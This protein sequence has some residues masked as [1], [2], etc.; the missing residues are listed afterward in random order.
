M[1]TKSNANQQ[2]QQNNNESGWR[3]DNEEHFK[4]LKQI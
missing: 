4:Y 3:I 1:S 2:K